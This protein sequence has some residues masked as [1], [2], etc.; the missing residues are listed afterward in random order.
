MPICNSTSHPAVHCAQT[1]KRAGH[2]NQHHRHAGSRRLWRRS[3]ARAQHV[4][5]CERAATLLV[6]SPLCEGRP[7]PS[8]SRSCSDVLCFGLRVVRDAGRANESDVPGDVSPVF[9]PHWMHMALCSHMLACVSACRRERMRQVCSCWWTR[10]RGPCRRR[11]SC[12]AR[13][14]SSTRRSSWW[15]TRSTAPPPGAALAPRGAFRSTY[16]S[17]FQCSARRKEPLISRK[18]ARRPDNIRSLI[19]ILSASAFAMTCVPPYSGVWIH[20]LPPG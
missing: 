2:Q 6:V 16:S 1:G 19:S 11:G 20:S 15:S 9:P 12:C 13:P 17:R 10:W 4:R 14:W 3:G 7:S 8:A 5:R 18:G